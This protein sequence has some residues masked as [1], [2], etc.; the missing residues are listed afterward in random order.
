MERDQGSVEMSVLIS[1][2]GH[3][4]TLVSLNIQTGTCLENETCLC[5]VQVPSCWRLGHAAAGKMT[6]CTCILSSELELG[7]HPGKW[8]IF[9]SQ[10][11]QGN[12]T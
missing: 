3:T 1:T 10:V 5:P 4:G 8:E 12:S 6:W 2:L 11:S 9:L 7:I